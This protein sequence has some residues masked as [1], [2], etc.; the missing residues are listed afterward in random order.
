MRRRLVFLIVALLALPFDS[1]LRPQAVA[2]APSGQGAPNSRA[3]V[4]GGDRE[5]P[6]YEY[7][8]DAG[9]PAG[10]N[11]HLI[12]A[13]ARESGMAVDIHLGQRDERMRDFEEGR[14]DLMFASYSE[15][16]A[17]KYQFLDQPWT[18]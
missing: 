1:P 9:Q 15:D 14:T 4:Y 13:L 5:F 17:A 11:I 16:R 10:F 12:R 8:D 18:L 6:P 2:T 3:L 7:I